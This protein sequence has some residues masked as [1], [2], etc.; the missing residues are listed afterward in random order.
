MSFSAM[1]RRG[2]GALPGSK[3]IWLSS[4]KRS[5]VLVVSQFEKG[6]CGD[7]RYSPPWER[8]GECAQI[9]RSREASTEGRRGGGFDQHPIIGGL[10]NRPVRANKGTEAFY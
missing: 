5:A 8:R 3:V 6:R 1:D 7:C 9:K 2:R 4:V 10:T